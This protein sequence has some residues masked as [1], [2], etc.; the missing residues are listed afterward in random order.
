MGA[1]G[2]AAM[3][4]MSIG[5][6]YGQSQALKNQS[7]FET[8]QMEINAKFQNMQAEDALRRGEREAVN[9]QKKVKQTVGAQR[10]AMAASGIQIDTEG[11][12]ASEIQKQTYEIGAEDAITIKN[13]AWREAWG[14]KS[15]AIQS[16][17]QGAV[18][19][20]ASRNAQFNTFLTGGINAG[21]YFMKTN[22]D[23]K[24]DSKTKDT[25]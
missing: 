14:F 18:A 7:Q 8:R 20:S 19:R 23:G 5:Q 13:N 6:A 1:N 4:G 16:E 22:S 2:S 25:E 10:A 15:Q 11:T 21:S 9:Y 12:S 3:A 17:M 24:K